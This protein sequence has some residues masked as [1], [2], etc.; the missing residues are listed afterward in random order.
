MNKFSFLLRPPA[1]S[2]DPVRGQADSP[3][4]GGKPRPLRL[5]DTGAAGGA[6]RLRPELH[7]VRLLHQ[8]DPAQRGA[9]RRPVVRGSALRR[10]PRGRPRLLRD[11]LV[12]PRSRPG[13]RRRH[14]RR[15]GRQCRRLQQLAHGVDV[16]SSGPDGVVVDPA[17]PPR[18]APPP[19]TAAAA[20]AEAATPLTFVDDCVTPPGGEER[21]APQGILLCAAGKHAQRRYEIPHEHI[22][23]S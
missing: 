10:R 1:A 18:R 15:R 3:S 11:L 6:A 2:G 22:Y 23:F 16:G 20:A 7:P 19:A 12:S 14:S 4:E 5:G 8:Q 13:S 21:E 17:A 9:P